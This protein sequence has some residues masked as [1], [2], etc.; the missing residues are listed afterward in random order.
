MSTENLP[1]FSSIDELVDKLYKQAKEELRNLERTRR[2][3]QRKVA[4]FEKILGRQ[5]TASSSK[6]T[7]QYAKTTKRRRAVQGKK[8]KRPQI[9]QDV[10]IQDV[11]EVMRDAE[12]R[13]MNV[14]KLLRRLVEDK[15]YPETE[16]FR[17]R[18]YS[19]MSHWAQDGDF[20]IRESR[21][22]YRL[23][24]TEEGSKDTPKE[25]SDKPEKTAR[26][27]GAYRKRS[28]N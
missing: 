19:S 5:S 27:K 22:I 21:G 18:L 10:L 8:Y 7:K 28:A 20:L 24:E 11:K 6:D 25:E 9:K 13:T 16:S 17:T 23:S 12:A 4:K 3:V 1:E 14:C 2:A 15:S 26:S